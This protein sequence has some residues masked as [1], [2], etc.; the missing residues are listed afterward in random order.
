MIGLNL[1]QTL[2]SNWD[3]ARVSLRE[4]LA[5]IE[6]I[7]STVPSGVR[8]TKVFY[9]AVTSG[10]AVTTKLTFENGILIRVG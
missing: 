9:V 2:D 7:L 6:R 3:I 10:G 5:T 4:D 1:S 8:G